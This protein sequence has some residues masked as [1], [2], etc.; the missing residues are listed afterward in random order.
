MSG[1]LFHYSV[2][3][4]AVTSNLAL[5]G[6]H[7]PAGQGSPLRIDAVR[8]QD[9][10]A[11]ESPP[12][13][14]SGFEAHWHV[15]DG[16]WLS[17]Y[18]EGSGTPLW[19]MEAHSGG[20]QLDVRWSEPGQLHDIPAVVQGAGFAMALHLRGAFILH[21]SVVAVA[22]RA[23]LVI[24]DSGA[25]KSS[26][27]AALVRGGC[28]LVSDDMAVLDVVGEGMAVRRGPLRMRVY[29]DSARAAGWTGTLPKLFR[30]PIFEDK[31][32]IDVT[33][34]LQSETAGVCA[35]FVLE[36][37]DRSAARLSVEPLS[38]RAALGPLLRNIYRAPFLDGARGKIAAERCAW[39]AGSIPVVTVHRLDSLDALP[40]IAAAITQY[41]SALV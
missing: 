13:C 29:E 36:P 35:I 3:G 38:P 15:E 19:A 34:T 41:A 40:D 27:A 28:P 8:A 10:A 14:A 20:A 31:R 17:R 5:P 33:N 25:G 37:R 1:Q 7:P 2:F 24:G 32:Y 9:F 16:R 12:H 4:L 26:T 18:G 11:P 23:I 22:G 39:I 6:L 30:H 21:A